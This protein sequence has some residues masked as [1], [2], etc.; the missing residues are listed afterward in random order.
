MQREDAATNGMQPGPRRLERLFGELYEWVESAVLAVVAVVLLFTFVARTSTVSGS[1]MVQ[2]LH[3]NDMLVVSR[4][5]Y[6]PQ[7]GDIVVVTKPNYENEPLVKRV[8]AT[9]GQSIN[10]DF[11]EGVVYV[12]GEALDEPYVNTPTNK[13]YDTVFPLI[14]PEGELFV[15]GDNRNGSIDSRSTLIGFIDERYVLGRAY[16]RILPL[17]SMERLY[18]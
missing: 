7:P 12:D 17:S 8:I 16:W 13:K 4:L 2:T 15:M 6:S 14:V 3:E 10:I 5:F 18:D 1:S 9:G 11:T